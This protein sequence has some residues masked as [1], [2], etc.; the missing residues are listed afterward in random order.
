MEEARKLSGYPSID[1]PW[2]KYYSGE[3]LS[4]PLPR[5]TMFEYVW[6]N[7]RDHLSDIALRY[8]GTKITYGKLFAEIRKAADALYA[9]GVRAGDIVTIMSMHTPEA[10]CAMYA[11]NW[12]GAVANMVY[13][14][15]SG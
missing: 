15:L 12:I 3:A 11:L 2:R 6:E 14:T 9:M 13:P 7:N 10:V 8:Y 4:A 5:C 1:Q